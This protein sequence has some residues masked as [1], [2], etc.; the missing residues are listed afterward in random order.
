MRHHKVS[1]KE[2]SGSEKSQ[3]ME[4]TTFLCKAL[5]K[6]QSFQMLLALAA[7]SKSYEGGQA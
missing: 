1:W 3:S 2:I 6:H 5:E 7:G 4:I